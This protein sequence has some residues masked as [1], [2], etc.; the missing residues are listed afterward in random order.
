LK[1]TLQAIND[2]V[3]TTD[4]QTHIT[5]INAAAEALLG[6]DMQAVEGRR[7]GF[8]PCSERLVT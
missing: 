5:Y 1:I 7:S 4:A 6:L 2:A 8:A 3:I